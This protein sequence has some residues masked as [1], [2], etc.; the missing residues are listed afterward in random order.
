MSKPIYFVI[1]TRA[2]LIKTAPVM[3]ELGEIGVPFISIYTGQHRETIED[4]WQGFDIRPADI[5]LSRQAKEAA[6]LFHFFIWSFRM[7]F[8]LFSPKRILKQGPGILVTHGDTTTSVWAALLGKIGG[9]KVAHLESGL[10]SFSLFH[11]FPEEINRRLIFFLADYYFCPNDWA[12]NNLKNFRG[13]KIN[14]RGNTLIDAVRIASE[15]G[16]S[17]R[18]IGEKY[19]LVSLHRF[20]N[21]YPG[22]KLKDN[23]DVVQKITKRYRVIFILHP[24]TKKR[25]ELSGL[26][27][28]LAK[29]P[30]I[31]FQSR[32]GFFDFI[33]VLDNAAFVLTDG[34]SNQEESSYLGVPCLL[35][36][37]RTERIEGLEQNVCLS[38]YDFVAIDG[39][40]ADPEKYRR[41]RVV[42]SHRPSALIAKELQTLSL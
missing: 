19:C 18:P 13:R 25:L 12:V 8:L 39:F 21:L 10:R 36:R 26:F 4:I 9:C 24:V 5:D 14:T 15:R 41:D 2:Q 22:K 31:T 42:G 3:K 23:C 16:S 40:V 38:G 32:L 33:K 1:G 28:D 7:F 17:Q 11:P 6:T 20:E 27:G 29:N 30:R 35:L 34:G 37:R